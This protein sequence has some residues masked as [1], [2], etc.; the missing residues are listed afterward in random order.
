MYLP[1]TMLELMIYLH[2]SNR[3]EVTKAIIWSFQFAQSAN[4]NCIFQFLFLF[5]YRLGQKLFKKLVTYHWVRLNPIPFTTSH[6]E[7]KVP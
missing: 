4:D 6:L 1:Q 5:Y 7:F 3:I 2:Q